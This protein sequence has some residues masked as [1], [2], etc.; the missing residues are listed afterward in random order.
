MRLCQIGMSNFH[1]FCSVQ[2]KLKGEKEIKHAKSTGND[3]EKIL[4]LAIISK[5]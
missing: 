5:L 1:L 3:A 2:I 4:H